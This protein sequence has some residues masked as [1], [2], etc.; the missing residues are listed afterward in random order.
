MLSISLN[1]LITIA[2]RKIEP[3]F[4]IRPSKAVEAAFTK[5]TRMELRE[6]AVRLLEAEFQNP[7]LFL[8]PISVLLTAIEH[9]FSQKPLLR[10]G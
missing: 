10:Y 5:A 1:K 3:D 6:A 2:L 9:F 8:T 7:A 4:E